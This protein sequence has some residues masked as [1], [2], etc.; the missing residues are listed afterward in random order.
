MRTTT[1]P[2][3]RFYFTIS[4]LGKLL[5]KSPVTLRG[6]ESHG[7]VTIPRDHSGDRRLT[8]DHIRGITK[9][10]LQAGRISKQRANLV[11]ATMTLIEQVE[12]D[13]NYKAKK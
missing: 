11:Y 13:N 8:T 2:N 5:C 12:N 1:R 10:A 9:I 6:W 3:W 7:F 4:D